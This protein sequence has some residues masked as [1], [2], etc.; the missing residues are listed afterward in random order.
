[1]ATFVQEHYLPALATYYNDIKYA[2]KPLDIGAG[3]WTADKAEQAIAMEGF[4]SPENHL[5]LY[6]RRPDIAEDLFA[7]TS[8]DDGYLKGLSAYYNDIGYE[9]APL[10]IG[11]GEWNSDNVVQAIE[12]E[13]FSIQEHFLKYARRPDILDQVNEQNP[14]PGTYNLF[15]DE[16]QDIAE[17]E[18]LKVTGAV[19]NGLDQVLSEN[20]SLVVSGQSGSSQYEVGNEFTFGVQSG[21]VRDFS[22]DM[23]TE[24]FVPGEYDLAVSYGQEKEE[25]QF[26]VVE[27]ASPEISLMGVDHN[28]LDG[29]EMN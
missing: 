28:E 1:M 2:Y 5:I 4:T 3:Q 18:A 6:G 21:D 8:F 15:V 16:P 26:Q 25:F 11:T 9:Y 19:A 23:D 7:D 14:L 10:K 20:L 12:N 27:S 13:G 29:L 24:V 22:V 17:G